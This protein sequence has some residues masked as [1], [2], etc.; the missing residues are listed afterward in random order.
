MEASRA[1]NVKSISN[2]SYSMKLRIAILGTRCIPNYYGGFEH[3]S[4]YV[5]EGL[6]KRG[7]SVTVYKSH[8]HPYKAD[9]WNGIEIRL[10]Y[11][12]VYLL[13]TAGQYVSYLN[14]PL[15]ARKQK[16]DA[17]LIKGYTSSSVCC[18]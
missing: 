9:T 7:H 4:E 2:S 18:K 14:S 10:C 13:G 12:P 8:N 6:V 11:D 1:A 15:D 17:I 16:P 5:S 3:I